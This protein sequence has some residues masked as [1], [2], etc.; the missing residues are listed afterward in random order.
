[1]KNLLRVV[2]TGRSGKRVSPVLVVGS[3]A[4][5][6]NGLPVACRF[7]NGF[8]CPRCGALREH[9]EENGYRICTS[10]GHK[11]AYSSSVPVSK[12]SLKEKQKY[13][14]SYHFSVSIAF[15]IL[16]TESDTLAPCL[17][18]KRLSHRRW[19]KVKNS[20][21]IHEYEVD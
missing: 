19:L 12:M 2:K 5:F 18:S 17:H 11:K 3:Q 6:S 21:P 14:D 16:K 20:F 8:F 1:M 4:S 7:I 9:V 13:R 15:W 10:C